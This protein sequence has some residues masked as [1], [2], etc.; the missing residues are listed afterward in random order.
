MSDFPT[1]PGMLEVLSVDEARKRT[2]DGAYAVMEGLLLA[3]LIKTG[4]GPL[5]A[6]NPNQDSC[7]P[8][9]HPQYRDSHPRVVVVFWTAPTVQPAVLRVGTAEFAL[10]GYDALEPG[11]LVTKSKAPSFA[12]IEISGPLVKQ[13]ADLI[14]TCFYF[15]RPR[16][17]GCR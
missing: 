8:P 9:I 13:G 5:S 17:C 11:V 14:G 12:L 6:C 16:A 10:L 4:D 15:P 1:Y 7:Y 3:E 2:F